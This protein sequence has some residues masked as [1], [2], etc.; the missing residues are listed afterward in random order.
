MIQRPAIE[1]DLR[2]LGLRPGAHVEVHSSLSSMGYIAGGAATV[3]DA[4]MHTVEPTGALAMSNYPVSPPLPV[5]PAERANGIAWKIRRLADD[6]DQRTGT[7]AIS[8]EFRRRPG[9]VCG[10][11]IHRICAW[12]ANAQTYATGYQHLVDNAGLVLLIGVDIDRCSSM[13]LADSTPIS[14]EAR[15][16][17]D[18]QWGPSQVPII[19]DIVQR[20]YPAD[21]ILGAEE[22]NHRRDPWAH[23]RQEADSRN[24]IKRGKIGAASCMLFK[25]QDLLDLLVAVR[26]SGPFG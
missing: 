24:L 8:D 1:R 11:G 20:Q 4:L 23:T 17:M 5:S 12:G 26:R 6:S 15:Q 3:V 13:H 18:S 10:A 21:I 2:T 22:T 16:K 19:A 7:G 9:V 14:A 25:A